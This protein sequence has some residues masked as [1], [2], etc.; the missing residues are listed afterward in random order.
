[1]DSPYGA[2]IDPLPYLA[3]AY[4]LGLV[5]LFGYGFFC[6]LKH[7]KLNQMRKTLNHKD[8]AN[9]GGS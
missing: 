4:A 2:G 6:F 3:F 5:L 7:G 8:G 9:K 1:M